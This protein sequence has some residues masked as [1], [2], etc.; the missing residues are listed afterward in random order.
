VRRG[1]G[2]DACAEEA[3]AHLLIDGTAPFLVDFLTL[4]IQLFLLHRINIKKIASKIKKV[5]FLTLVIELFL[6][7]RIKILNRLW[8][9]ASTA[10]RHF[11][12][13]F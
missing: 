3:W 9:S 1:G 6:L 10:Y 5:D 7:H 12:E 11:I 13:Y 8:P 4:V 2:E